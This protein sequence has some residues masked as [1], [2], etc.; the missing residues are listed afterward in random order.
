MLPMLT[1][2]PPRPFLTMPR[3]AVWVRKKMARSSSRYES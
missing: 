3:T 2:G 1:M